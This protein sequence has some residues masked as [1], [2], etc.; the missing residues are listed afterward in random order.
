M[1][2]QIV[3]SFF[4][5]EKKKNKIIIKQKH[6]QQRAVPCCT[7]KIRDGSILLSRIYYDG[8]CRDSTSGRIMTRIRFTPSGLNYHGIRIKNKKQRNN[9]GIDLFLFSY[10]WLGGGWDWASQTMATGPLLPRRIVSNFDLGGSRGGTLPTGSVWRMIVIIIIY[11]HCHLWLPK[12]WNR[13]P[14]GIAQ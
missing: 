10:R 12:R 5:L 11:P 6:V 3:D 1:K 14:L 9:K 8:G 13:Y 2:N 7:M 4:F